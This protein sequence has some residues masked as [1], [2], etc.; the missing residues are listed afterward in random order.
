MIYLINKTG[1]G[2]CRCHLKE[3]PPF[4]VLANNLIDDYTPQNNP[5]GKLKRNSLKK[6]RL[7]CPLGCP[8]G[9]SPELSLGF[10][11]WVVLWG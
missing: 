9:L 6:C 4:L 2:G 10:L 3:R 11:S 5:R 1:E 8:R 7:G